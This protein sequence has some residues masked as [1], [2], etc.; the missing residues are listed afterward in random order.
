MKKLFLPFVAVLLFFAA[1]KKDT[2]LTTSNLKK[3]DTIQGTITSNMTLDA[4]K[5]YFLK[6]QVFVKNNAVLTIPAGV[7]VYVQKND[8]AANKSV[9]VITQGAKLNVSGTVDKPVVF[10]SAA[11][12]KSPGDWGAIILLGK[13]PTNVGMGN[14][15]GLPASADTQYGG[16][17]SNDNS[18]SIT[19][20]RLEYCGGI[21]PPQEDEWIVDKAS[22]L[23][24]AGV[25]SGTNIFNVMVSHSNDDGFQFVG[26]TV[27]AANLI[28]YN[29]GDDDFDFDLGY[30]GKLQFLLSYRTLAFSQALRANGLESYNDQYPTTNPPLTRPVISNMTIIGPQ[31][32]QTVKTNLNQ[33]VYIRKGTRFAIRNSIIAEYPEGGLMVCNRTRPVLLSNTGSEFKYNLVHADTTARTFCWDQDVAVVADPE[34]TAFATNSVNNNSVITASGDLKLA[35]PYASV[36]DFTP[37]SGSAALT[38]ANF[39]GPDFSTPFTIVTYRGAIG[40]GSNW[41]AQSNWANWK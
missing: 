10:T 33:G 17:V 21:N 41:A 26:G 38:G 31:G 9:L 18:G 1:C 35:A 12:T 28:G 40:G 34:L 8:L 30:Q 25:G 16:T 22:G 24:L 29:N 19:F 4:S 37:Q 15:E 27:N 23:C 6:G 32:V 5:N 14:V 36:P 2:S 20:L 7:T 39:D 3:T 11:A 13:A